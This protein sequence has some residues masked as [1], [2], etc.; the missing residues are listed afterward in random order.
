MVQTRGCTVASTPSLCAPESMSG[1][2]FC[3]MNKSDQQSNV[4]H[5]GK[6]RALPRPWMGHGA[7]TILSSQFWIYSSPEDTWI[8]G[9]LDMVWNVVLVLY[10]IM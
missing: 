5:E 7:T 8:L 4:V 1:T 2:S 10:M 3:V 9:G 6:G